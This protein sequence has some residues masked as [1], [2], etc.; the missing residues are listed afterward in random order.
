MQ[1]CNK[2]KCTGCFQEIG[3]FGLFAPDEKKEKTCDDV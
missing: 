1:L 2:R 3:R